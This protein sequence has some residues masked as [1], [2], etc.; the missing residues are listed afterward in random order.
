M[1]IDFAGQLDEPR[2]FAV[3]SRQPGEIERIDGYAMSAETRTRVER[4]KTERLRPG[5]LDDLPHVNAQLVIEDLQLVDQ[6][7][8]DRPIRVFENLAGLSHL[9]AGNTNDLND[10]VAVHRACQFGAFFIEAADHLGYRGRLE[11]RIARIL[12]LRAEGEKVVGAADQACRFEERPDA[13]TSGRG[14]R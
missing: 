6:G 3:L 11:L 7:D 13:G 9:D 4:L 1:S 8:V 5:R 2:M 12:T 14:V 10:H